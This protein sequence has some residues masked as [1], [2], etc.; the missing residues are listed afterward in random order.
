[1]ASS[2][3]TVSQSLSPTAS[4]WIARPL[5]TRAATRLLWGEMS[6]ELIGPATRVTRTSTAPL[7]PKVTKLTLGESP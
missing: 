6:T 3:L 2:P 1:L 5:S 4:V 7:V